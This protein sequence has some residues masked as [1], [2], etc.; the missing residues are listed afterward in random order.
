[1]EDLEA[2]VDTT[3]GSAWYN[4]ST[5]YAG[6]EITRWEGAF[7]AMMRANCVEHHVDDFDGEVRFFREVLGCPENMYV[8][9]TLAAF[10]VADNFTVLVLPRDAAHPP[11]TNLKGETIDISVDL[12]EV[13]ALYER[14][15][16]K[17]ADIRQPPITQ[18]AGI[19]NFYF[20]TPGGLTIEYE[21][22]TTED[23]ARLLKKLFGQG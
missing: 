12:P 21:A 8:P 16:D 6:R 14:L 15:K 11:Y 13:D 18:P 20:E 10:K 17:G 23:G 3:G 5:L 19:R 2:V 7:P 1:M 22:P 9:D 4:P